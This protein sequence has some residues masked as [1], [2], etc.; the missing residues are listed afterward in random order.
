MNPIKKSIRQT[1]RKQMNRLREE[2]KQ[3]KALQKAYDKAGGF[4]FEGQKK[5]AKK[6][7]KAGIKRGKKTVRAV[8][9]S[10]LRS[11]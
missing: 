11:N 1:A 10:L 4:V 8:K 7:L 3:G 5:Q 6:N 2:K 9:R